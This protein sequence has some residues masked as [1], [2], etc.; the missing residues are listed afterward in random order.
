M[1]RGNEDYVR[2][3][4]EDNPGD[5]QD[6]VDGDEGAKN[7]LV[8]KIMAESGGSVTAGSAF[9][10]IDEILETDEPDWPVTFMVYRRPVGMDSLGERLA[11]EIPRWAHDEI[12]DNLDDPTAFEFGY[13]VTV[14]E[15][16]V[17]LIEGE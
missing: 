12:P 17:V 7:Y 14:H 2:E 10:L 4:L 3:V 5:V 13:E 11:G 6:Y 16:G 8:G 15:D 1:S 9:D